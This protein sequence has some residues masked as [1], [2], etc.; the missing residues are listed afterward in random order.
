MQKE[1][2]K[3]D[4]N[5]FPA[6]WYSQMPELAETRAGTWLLHLL[7]SCLWF[8]SRLLCG[9]DGMDGDTKYATLPKIPLGTKEAK[10]CKTSRNN[11][12]ILCTVQWW[13]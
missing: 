5:H 12:K 3:G 2:K 1:A 9:P 10:L 4:L 7:L 13:F 6:S 11:C 8:Q